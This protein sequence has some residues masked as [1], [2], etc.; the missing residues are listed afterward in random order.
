[1]GPFHLVD[2]TEISPASVRLRWGVSHLGVVI[3][4]FEHRAD[5]TMFINRKDR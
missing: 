3:A 2:M 5:A 4:Q 1:M